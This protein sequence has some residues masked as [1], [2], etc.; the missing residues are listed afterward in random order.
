MRLRILLALIPFACACSNTQSV[1]NNKEQTKYNSKESAVIWQ[2]TSG[3]YDALC[4]QAYNVA[5]QKLKEYSAEQTKKPFAIILDLD[6]TVLNNSPYNGYL[7]LNNK[8][9]SSESWDEWVNLQKAELIAGAHEFLKQADDIGVKVF[10]VSNRK[11][12][13]IDATMANLMRY[14]LNY[15]AEYFL[16]KSETSVKTERRERVV[17]EH[18]V[19]LYLGDNLA[20][21]DDAFE[22]ELTATM[23]K[24][25]TNN[26]NYFSHF[27]NK[28]IIFPNP[29]YGNWE[30]ALRLENDLASPD[31]DVTKVLKG[32]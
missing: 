21:F 31:I 24:N 19:I 13:H 22:G 16:L 26:E 23:R 9:Y 5:L 2:Q 20:D 8:T 10:F 11:E 14:D 3:E 32:F 18:N 25:L 28:F 29:M 12:K 6:E 30:K 7:L 4:Y 15:G 1:S 17:A 27:G